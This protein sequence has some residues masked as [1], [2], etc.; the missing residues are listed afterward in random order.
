[1]KLNDIDWKNAK[2]LLINIS[3]NIEGIGIRHLSSFIKK[4]NNEV[5]LL[6]LKHALEGFSYKYQNDVVSFINYH[7]FN[8]IGFSCMTG[9]YYECRSLTKLIKSRIKNAVVIWGGVHPTIVPNE[10]LYGGGADIVFN[11]AAEIALEKLL[12]GTS[13]QETPNI[14]WCEGS[15]EE[16]EIFSNYQHVDLNSPDCMPFPDYDFDDHFI[17]NNGNIV[18]LTQQLYQANSLWKGSHYFG[19]TARGCPYHCSYCCNI[20]RGFFKRKSVDYFI[21][22]LKYI[23]RK[24]PFTQTI[25]VQDDSLFMHNIEWVNNFAGNYRK[26]IN[27]P[28]RAALMPKF[29]TLDKLHALSSAGL[30]YIGMGLQGSSRLNKEIYNRNESSESFLVAVENCKKIGIVIRVDVIIDNPYETHNDLLEIANTL[31]EIS[32]PFPILVYSLTLFPGTKLF[33]KA[34]NDCIV[35]K[36]AGNPYLPGLG[37]DKDNKD[38]KY[39]TP[40]YWRLLYVH[41]LPNLPKRFCRYLI[42]NI[43]NNNIQQK[44]VKYYKFVGKIRVIG[45]KMRQISPKLFDKSLVL[46]NKI[47]HPKS[48]I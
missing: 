2:I 38:K 5:S 30:T 41:F 25:S 34:Y 29:A 22:E 11:G 44:V 32:K 3:F 8:V 1:M 6:F 7:N 43:S 48:N 24:L 12:A 47:L 4:Y 9:D 40:D 17:I 10:C 14:A 31:N 13:L 33:N 27:K 36:F 42:N 15:E 19:I 16:K 39:Y 23:Q 37:A 45:E 28:L 46:M 20:Y 26:Y 21:E 18:K 35:N